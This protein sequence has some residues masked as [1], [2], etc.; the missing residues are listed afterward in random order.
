MTDYIHDLDGNGWPKSTFLVIF[1]RGH[2]KIFFD[3]DLLNRKT[4]NIQMFI[5]RGE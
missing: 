4:E 2:H 5:I 3:K 1:Y